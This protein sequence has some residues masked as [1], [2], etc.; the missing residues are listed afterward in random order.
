MGAD[1]A[2]SGDTAG[3]QRKF[4]EGFSLAEMAMEHGPEVPQ[5]YK[6]AAI[7]TKKVG[8]SLP[9][10]EKIQDTFKIKELA[11]KAAE[12]DDMDATTQHLIGAWYFNVA[13]VSWIER[14]VAGTLFATVPSATYEE[15]EPY[16]LRSHE[17]DNTLWENDVLLGD[18]YVLIKRTD[19]AKR[20]YRHMLD[21]QVVTPK[22]QQLHDA[23]QKK[24]NKLR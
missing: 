14:K 24:F 5:G 1:L 16:L 13:N 19:E 17:L 10:K 23:V 8:E 21:R 20:W 11:L 3:A 15:A 7:L 9:L 4:K 22:E 18:M 6:W 12:L 2:A